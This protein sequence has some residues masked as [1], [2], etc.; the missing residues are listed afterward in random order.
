MPTD[1]GQKFQQVIHQFGKHLST[2]QGAKPWRGRGNTEMAAAQISVYLQ[3]LVGE[4]GFNTL[5]PQCVK[6]RIKGGAKCERA[7]K[8]PMRWWAQCAFWNSPEKILGGKQSPSV[9]PSHTSVP[10]ATQD[11]E[12]RTWRTV[13]PHM[14]PSALTTIYGSVAFVTF[15]FHS[16]LPGLCD[17]DENSA[18]LMRWV[19]NWQETSRFVY[20]CDKYLLSACCVA[21]IGPSIG[22]KRNGLSCFH[23]TYS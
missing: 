9:C 4:Q 20:L 11:A 14:F 17:G 5:R 22:D 1:K 21:G 12:Y 18:H 2:G 16:V 10:G 8:G 6:D 7:R 19:R 3:N 15:L 23:G 13:C